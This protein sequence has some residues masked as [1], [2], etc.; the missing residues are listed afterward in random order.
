MLFFI[1]YFHSLSYMYLLYIYYMQD[2]IR[3][4]L[5]ILS[6]AMFLIIQWWRYGS[7]QAITLQGDGCHLCLWGSGEAL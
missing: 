4:Q 6:A 5:S 1:R 2:S 7:K 3:A